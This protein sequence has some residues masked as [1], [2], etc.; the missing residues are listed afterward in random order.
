MR[1]ILKLVITAAIFAFILPMIPGIDFHGSF[2]A[3]MLLAFFFGII[4]WLVDLVA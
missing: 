2:W 4:L 1:F 3:A